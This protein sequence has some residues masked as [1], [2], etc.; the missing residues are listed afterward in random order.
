MRISGNNRMRCGITAFFTCNQLQ[1]YQK[2][3]ELVKT[4]SKFLVFLTQQIRVMM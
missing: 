4:D 1:K 3:N 2:K